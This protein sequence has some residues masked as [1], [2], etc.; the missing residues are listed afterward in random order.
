[1]EI[2]YIVEIEE[3]I[4][5]VEQ[6]LYIDMRLALELRSLKVSDETHARLTKHGKYGESM[7]KIIAK[8]LDYYEGKTKK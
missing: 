3:N 2:E 6:F 4:L 7:D 8:I 1:V 5:E